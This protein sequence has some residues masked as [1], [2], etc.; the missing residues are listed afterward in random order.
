MLYPKNSE[1]ILDKELFKNPSNE[2]RGAPFWAWNCELDK[3][4][5]ISQTH[6]FQ[7]MDLEVTMHMFVPD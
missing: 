5:V 1:K 6:I 4:E 7:E 3:E 2:Y